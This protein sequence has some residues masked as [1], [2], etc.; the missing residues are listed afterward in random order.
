MTI[1]QSKTTQSKHN[2]TSHIMPSPSHHIL[3]ACIKVFSYFSLKP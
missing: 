3:I 1:I 2:A